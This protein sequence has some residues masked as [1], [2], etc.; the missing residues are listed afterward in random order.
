MKIKMKTPTFP[1]ILLLVLIICF[2]V[3]VFNKFYK[4]FTNKEGFVE[5]SG[6][7]FVR[8]T[9]EDVFD[10][11][12]ANMYDDLFYDE[13]KNNYEIKQILGSDTPQRRRKILDIGCSTGH[14]VYLLDHYTRD[15]DREP[16]SSVIAQLPSSSVIAQLPSSSVIGIDNSPAMIQK[17]QKNYPNLHFKLCDALNSMAFPA[18]T[19]THITCLY[20]TIYYMKD[21]KQFFENCY[22]WLEPGGVLVL[23]LVD[24]HK[25]DPILPIADRK[26]TTES[27]VH[28]E[29]LDYKSIFTI[30]PSIDA[31]SVILDKPNAVIRETIKIKEPVKSVRIN[32]HNMYM[33]SQ[34]SIL[35]LAKDVGFTLQSVE[36]MKDVRYDHNFLYVLQKTFS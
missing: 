22:N 21:K 7:G 36:E 1:E 32:E 35:G 28:F 31:T 4:R 20:F 34:N 19:F 11:F 24:M 14:H 13:D 29:T 18:E 33:S 30:D 25:F 17:A 5:R 15:G 8:K 6:D 26:S 3:V 23:H 9:D 27:I 2:I 12:Y 16:S 10:R